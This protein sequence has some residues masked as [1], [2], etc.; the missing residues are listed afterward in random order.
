MNQEK[1]G[2][3]SG[4]PDRLKEAME[5]ADLLF[6]DVRIPYNTERPEQMQALAYT[7]G[8]D[9]HVAPGQEAH[10]PHEVGHVV[11]Q[12]RGRV[13]ANQEMKKMFEENV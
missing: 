12:Y 13:D 5:M 1:K 8:T 3:T 11:Q 2:K 4:I 9:I 10:M 7:Q 6:D